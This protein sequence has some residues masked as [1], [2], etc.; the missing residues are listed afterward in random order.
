VKKRLS[1]NSKQSKQSTPTPT[2]GSVPAK[3]T[4]T[5]PL[6]SWEAF[7]MSLKNTADAV[8]GDRS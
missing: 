2:R 8:D 4:F 3:T 7:D 1:K 5:P 6:R